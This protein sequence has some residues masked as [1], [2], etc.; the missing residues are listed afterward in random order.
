[1]QFIVGVEKQKFIFKKIAVSSMFLEQ[2]LVLFKET[3]SR[4]EYMNSIF[5]YLMIVNVIVK[6]ISQSRG[7]NMG[8]RS[9]V[10]RN[11]FFLLFPLICGP[12]SLYFEIL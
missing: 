4:W 9:K 10:N 12:S 11:Q 8:G 6:Q 3:I 2:T 7:R 1:M 5:R